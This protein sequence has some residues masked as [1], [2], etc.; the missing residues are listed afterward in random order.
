M[1]GS[2]IWAGNPMCLVCETSSLRTEDVHHISMKSL[3]VVNHWLKRKCVTV[4]QPGT[5]K[6]EKESW[7]LP[8]WSISGQGGREESTG[9]LQPE[10]GVQREVSFESTWTFMHL[11]MYNMNENLQPG[12][13]VAGHLLCPHFQNPP[14]YR[15]QGHLQ[16]RNWVAGRQERG[17]FFL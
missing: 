15:K 4:T 3:F 5:L 1:F 16:D 7:L 8:S 10:L 13:N 17:P 2:L 12:N 6:T 14:L 11:I 9:V